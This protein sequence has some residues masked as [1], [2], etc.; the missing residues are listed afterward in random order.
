[1]QDIETKQDNSKIFKHKDL[2]CLA[3]DRRKWAIDHSRFIIA[4][5]EFGVCDGGH[6]LF[7]MKKTTR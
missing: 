3:G 4:S 5:G 7:V 1:L 2:L 6:R